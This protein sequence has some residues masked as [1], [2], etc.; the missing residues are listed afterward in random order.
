MRLNP[1]DATLYPL[2]ACRDAV[3]PKA[4]TRMRRAIT[5]L[6]DH[7]EQVIEI[8]RRVDEAH[9]DERISSEILILVNRIEMCVQF[10]R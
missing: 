3:E 1:F 2:Q 9:V 5:V 10:H 7:A 6:A 8:L 4:F